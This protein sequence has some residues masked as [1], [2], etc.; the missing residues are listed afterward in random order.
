[1]DGATMQYG[2]EARSSFLDQD[3]WGI[4]LLVAVA[5]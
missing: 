4:C 2:L 3:V 1:M 5:L